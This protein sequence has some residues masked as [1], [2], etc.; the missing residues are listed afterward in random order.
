MKNNTDLWAVGIG[1]MASLMKGLKNKLDVKTLIIA[2]IIG[3]IL[4][5][6]TL[7]LLDLLFSDLQPRVI[8]LVSFAVGWVA[9]ELTD[10]LD[11]VIK[12][13]YEL[14]KSWA[15]NRFNKSK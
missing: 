12:D 8:M 15:K 11:Q 5:Y 4:S 7:G 3:A 10:V 9:N 13:G 2:V 6:G 1:I 14:L